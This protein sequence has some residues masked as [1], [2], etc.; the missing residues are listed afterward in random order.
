[1]SRRAT[2]TAALAVAFAPFA[3]AAA[4]ACRS[5][6]SL[7]DPDSGAD[8][9]ATPP[10]ST[11]V[12][13][14]ADGPV[15]TVVATF[16]DTWGDLRALTVGG[17]MLHALFA[18]GAAGDGVL[19]RVATTGSL[20]A[21]VQVAQV[22]ADPS[23]LARTSDSS[24]VFAAARGGSQIFRVDP[25]GLVVI[26]NAGGVP[27]ALAADDHGGAF[28]ALSAKDSLFA[29]TFASGA[30]AAIATSP[31]PS[32]M[33]RVAGTLYVT[34]SG[35]MSSF[36]PA[37]DAAP[38]KI[39]DHCDSGVAAVSDTTLYCADAGTIVSIDIPTGAT[40]VLATAQPEAGDVAVVAGR[41]FWRTA[42]NG[43]QQTLLM[44]LPLDRIGGPTIVEASEPGPLFIASDGCD[45]YF[46]AGRAFVRLQL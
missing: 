34:G 30:P 46:T 22:G 18:R 43:L 39:A 11:V 23:A 25:N 31:R 36:D 15:R 20:G 19:A 6:V 38:R 14:C 17:G 4:G 40:T 24:F 16:D 5:Q 7:G 44:A 27:S 26:A 45:L 42:P 37:H 21:L 29:W 9:P 3:L 35:S 13:R 2:A 41:V 32:W 10:T 33:T 28:W 12:P 1:V 8:A